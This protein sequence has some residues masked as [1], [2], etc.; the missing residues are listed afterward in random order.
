MDNIIIRKVREHPDMADTAARWFHEKWGSP[1]LFSPI[2][3]IPLL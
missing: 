1:L 3:T 2:V